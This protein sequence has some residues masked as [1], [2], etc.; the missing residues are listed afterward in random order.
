MDETTMLEWVE[1]VWWPWCQGRGMTYLILDEFSAHMTQRVLRAIES[2]NTV[3]DFI[4]GGYTSKLQPLDV[5]VNKPFKGF[6]RGKFEL[7]MVQHNGIV[8]HHME[9][10][11]WV[12]YAW[13][14][15]TKSTITNTWRHIGIG[16][17]N[18]QNEPDS[19]SDFNYTDEEDEAIDIL[20]HQIHLHW[21]MKMRTL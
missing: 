17:G 11:R 20:I 5:G 18:D 19:D 10:S 9:V 3:L 16:G 2:C 1:K 8:P 7:F 21:M 6:M 15:I 13:S 4:I 12:E 14:M